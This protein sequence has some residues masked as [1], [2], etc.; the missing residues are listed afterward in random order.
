[1]FWCLVLPGN[2]N[3]TCEVKPLHCASCIAISCRAI[4]WLQV[5]GCSVNTKAT[6]DMSA[7]QASK[8]ASWDSCAQCHRHSPLTVYLSDT[9]NQGQGAE[10]PKSGAA[11]RMYG[12]RLSHWF[13]RPAQDFQAETTG[14]QETI[15]ASTATSIIAS[16]M[17]S[18]SSIT[19]LL[20][21]HLFIL[22]LPNVHCMQFHC[23]FL[24]DLS[25]AAFETPRTRV[26]RISQEKQDCGQ[27]RS[28]S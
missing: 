19:R 16:I 7:C 26:L 15:M 13:A 10:V 3:C 1:V 17:S 27:T 12:P 21:Y 23:G 4:I 14:S 2:W 18:P 24:P 8:I 11:N 25:N 20:Q 9:G 5:A 28:D 22:V 6:D